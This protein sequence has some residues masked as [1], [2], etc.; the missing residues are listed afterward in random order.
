MNNRKEEKV[1]RGDLY[2][3]DLSPVCGSEQGGIRPVVVIQND[4][5][6]I[7][8]PT[9]IVAAT[10]SQLYKANLPTHV[11][12]RK[13][14]LNQL[15]MD[16][17][18]LLEQIRTIDRSRLGNYIGRLTGDAMLALDYALSVS[19]GLNPHIGQP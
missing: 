9:V 16:T 5:G 7:H 3:A 15:K 10:T 13:S 18:A 12:I 11:L 14:N 6:N 8:S 1:Q 2:Y 19:I 4:R 17:V